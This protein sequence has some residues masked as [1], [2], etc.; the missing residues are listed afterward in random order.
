MQ[1]L[2]KT[3]LARLWNN[4]KS[5]LSNKEDSSNKVTSIDS[6]STNNQYPSAKAVYNLFNNET[7]LYDN[8]TGSNEAITLSYS[9]DNYKFIDIQFKVGATYKS[10]R[11]YNP[12]R[13][14]IVLDMIDF[15]SSRLFFYTKIVRCEGTTISNMRYETYTIADSSTWTPYGEASNEIYITRIVGYN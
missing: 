12:N 1:Y 9:F 2:D 15:V 8:S 10:V 14:N 11:I 6:T 3:G 7:V 5:K 13:K 4:I